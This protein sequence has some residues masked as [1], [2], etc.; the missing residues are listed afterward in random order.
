VLFTCIRS[1][2]SGPAPKLQDW[3][4]VPLAAARPHW[5]PNAQHASCSAGL[6]TPHHTSCLRLTTQCLG[7]RP[8]T[9]GGWGHRR[10]GHQQFRTHEHECLV[11]A[12]GQDDKDTVGALGRR[13]RTTNRIGMA[14]VNSLPRSHIICCPWPNGQTLH[15]PMG[16]VSSQ[17]R[18]YILD[19][20]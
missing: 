10:G 5:L 15:A 3:L 11:G 7:R 20:L 9:I 13:P 1:A 8:Q 4:S 6:G 12:D 14:P 17:F 18:P 16:P 19:F 2:A